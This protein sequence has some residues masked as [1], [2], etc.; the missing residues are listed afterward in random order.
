MQSGNDTLLDYTFGGIFINANGSFI[1]Q[2]CKISRVSIGIHL[3]I[4]ISPGTYHIKNVE[5]NNCS[6]GIYSSWPHVVLNISNCYIHD[7]IGFL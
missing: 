2:N 1:I 4:G 7:S 3:S 5:I 6:I